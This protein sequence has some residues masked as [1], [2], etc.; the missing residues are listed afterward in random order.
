LSFRRVRLGTMPSRP[1]RQGT[2]WATISKRL[3]RLQRLPAQALSRRR[4]DG[5]ATDDLGIGST[6][7]LLTQRSW[8]E[9]AGCAVNSCA[10]RICSGTTPA[11]ASYKAPPPMARAVTARFFWRATGVPLCGSTDVFRGLLGAE[12][13][14]I[15]RRHVRTLM[16]RMGIEA[17]Y[18]RP[19]TTKP[20]PGH[21]HPASARTKP[22][23]S[24]K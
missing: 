1:M 3:A 24:R 15:D 11:R 13:S 2:E 20:E 14:K 23:I 4:R 21:N 7:H 18:Q 17:L 16:R 10:T 9:V 5:L 19:R 6:K 8:G 12:G 22:N